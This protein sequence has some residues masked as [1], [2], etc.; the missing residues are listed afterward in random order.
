MP[1]IADRIKRSRVSTGLSQSE[2]ARRIGVKP[3]AIQAIEAGNVKKPRYIVNL[4]QALGVSAQYLENG[5]ENGVTSFTKGMP[6][7]GSARAGAFLDITMIDEP[8]DGPPTIGVS[9]DL[10]F[11]YAA[12]YALLIDGESMNRRFIN[13]TYVTCVSWAETGLELKP[14]MCLHVE[15][16]QA[17]LTEITIKMYV[18]K[19]GQRL[20]YP[21]S[22]DSR[23]SPIPLE[24]DEGT[25]IIIKGLVTGSW[26]P[27]LF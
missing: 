11:P 26:K 20:L 25:E 24:G 4:A 21:D 9:T 7:L 22:T 2:L 23:F 12:Q 10:R 19:D 17:G 15:R 6:V 8:P 1:T 5:N 14:G 18:E 13:G 3:Q 27:E 16:Y